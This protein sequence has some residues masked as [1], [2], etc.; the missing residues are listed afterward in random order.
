[1][2]GMLGLFLG[3]LGFHNFYLGYKV[4]GYIQLAMGLSVVL[5][6][7]SAIWGSIEGILILVGMISKDANGNRLRT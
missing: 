1:M 3:F 2:A 5:T 4:K 6:V 7:I